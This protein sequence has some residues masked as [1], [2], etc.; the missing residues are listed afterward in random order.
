M[1]MV[2]AASLLCFFWVASGAWAQ[3]PSRHSSVGILNYGQEADTRVLQFRSA[4]RDL[5]Y[6]EGKDLTVIYRG[7]DGDLDRLPHLAAEL[8]DSRVDIIIALGPA[9]WAARRVT[10][11]IP[12]VIAFSG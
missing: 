8:V 7:A 12:I 3:P 6:H 10:S 5:G 9:V 2:V 1:R 4:L 11:T